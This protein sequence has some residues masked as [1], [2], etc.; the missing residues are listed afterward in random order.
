MR[1]NFPRSAGLSALERHYVEL[2]TAAQSDAR[3]MVT[4]SLN[5]P[6]LN[7]VYRAIT[8]TGRKIA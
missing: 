4:G 5:K 1:E 8:P 7:S 3:H 2:V 6:I